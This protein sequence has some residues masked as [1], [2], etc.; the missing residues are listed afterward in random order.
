MVRAIV[1]AAV[2]WGGMQAMTDTDA[3]LCLAIAIATPVLVGLLGHWTHRRD[4][5]AAREKTRAE[6]ALLSKLQL[7][8]G[9]PDIEAMPARTVNREALAQDAGRLIREIDAAVRQR[10]PAL[11]RLRPASSALCAPASSVSR[12]GR[13]A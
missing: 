3:L 1:C 12:R 7:L 6:Q 4:W 9:P 2:Q 13:R 11:R 8:G 5:R 10:A